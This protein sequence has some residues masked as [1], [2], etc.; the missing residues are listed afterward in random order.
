MNEKEKTTVVN[1]LLLLS[2]IDVNSSKFKSVRKQVNQQITENLMNNP[3][4]Q[5]VLRMLAK[6]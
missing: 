3:D 2:E 4:I 5:E 1:D 6:V